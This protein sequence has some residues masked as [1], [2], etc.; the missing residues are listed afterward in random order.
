MPIRPPSS[1]IIATRKPRPSSPSSASS[2][3]SMSLNSSG[4]V[5][6]PCCP[7][8]CSG[9]PRTSPGAS[10]FTKKAVMPDEPGASEVFAHTTNR[11]ACVPLVIHSFWPVSTQPRS[12]FWARVRMPAGSLPAPASDSAK[13]PTTYSPLH[14]RGT[15]SSRCSGVPNL[16]TTSATMLL[17]VIATV[18]LAQARASS[19]TASA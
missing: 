16:V 15:C 18:V 14:S 12:V 10:P 9:L 3:S 13:P 7:S 17:T 11:P 5:V 2:P 1:A 19:T 8:L 6:L 4:V